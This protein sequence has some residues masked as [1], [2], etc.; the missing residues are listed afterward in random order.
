MTT[1]LSFFSLIS[2]LISEANNGYEQAT[3]QTKNMPSQYT[4]PKIELTLKGRVVNDPNPLFAISDTQSSNLYGLKDESQ[5]KLTLKP[6]K[7]E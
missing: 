2:G 7:Q 6:Q 3:N 5:I 4:I 1:F